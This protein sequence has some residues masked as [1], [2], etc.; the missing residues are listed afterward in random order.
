MTREE[1]REAARRYGLRLRE[2]DCGSGWVDGPELHLGSHSYTS[3]RPCM[4]CV[5]GLRL[6][7]RL[8]DLEAA[9]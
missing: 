6:L 3:V 8:A 9:A 4:A 7:R 1:R 2:C 5:E